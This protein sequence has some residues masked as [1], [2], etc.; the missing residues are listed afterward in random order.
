MLRVC[1]QQQ[2]SLGLTKRQVKWLQN[3]ESKPRESLQFQVS[4]AEDPYNFLLFERHKAFA[5]CDHDESEVEGKM[6]RFTFEQADKIYLHPRLGRGKS[7][8][9]LRTRYLVANTLVKAKYGELELPDSFRSCLSYLTKKQVELALKM[10]VNEDV[11]YDDD[12]FLVD[13]RDRLVLCRTDVHERGIAQRISEIHSHLDPE[14]NVDAEDSELDDT[15]KE[16]VCMAMQ[17]GVSIIYGPPGTGKTKVIGSIVRKLK[18]REGTVLLFADT[19][20]LMAPTGMAAKNM[21]QKVGQGLRATTIHRVLYRKYSEDQLERCTT[22]ILDEAS[23][24]DYEICYRILQRLPNL[25]RLV[26]VG[27]DNQLPSIGHG[28]ILRDLIRSTVPGIKLRKMYRIGDNLQAMH[29]LIGIAE[30]YQ[31]P[32]GVEGVFDIAV[33]GGSLE[34]LDENNL[35]EIRYLW[36]KMKKKYGMGNVT[37]ITNLKKTAAVLTNMLQAEENPV[38]PVILEMD[39]E[40]VYYKGKKQLRGCVKGR[41]RRKSMDMND[42]FFGYVYDVYV[43]YDGI[44]KNVGRHLLRPSVFL[45]NDLVQ[46]TRNVG[47]S[48]VNGDAGTYQCKVDVRVCDNCSRELRDD[49]DDCGNN[50]M[51]SMIIDE[52]R[53][54]VMLNDTMVPVVV[55]FDHIDHAYVWTVHKYQGQQSDAVLFVTG[56]CFGKAPML[57]T[58]CSRWTKGMTLVTTGS[59]FKRML[60]PDSPRQTRL[61]ELVNEE[62]RN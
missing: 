37:C 16:A 50:C 19:V 52:I 56:S 9:K 32:S 38:T 26:L 62:L 18:R 49:E 53:H 55:P 39:Q 21:T 43:H 34:S 8:D 51:N 11:L 25:E 48:Y 6:P 1:I 5:V 30:E 45:E 17:G 28:Q 59:I 12:L 46:L 31:E 44:Q 40:V 58:G 20:R 24:V 36:R 42:D 10:N 22:V 7:T 35:L 41:R 13:S 61:Q 14:M 2:K 23:L 15:Q 3:L 57:Y 4:L 33:C 54:R 47:D 27:D 60:G 29:Q